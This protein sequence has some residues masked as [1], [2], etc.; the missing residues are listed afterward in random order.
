MI[1]EN[2]TRMSPFSAIEP[3]LYSLDVCSPGFDIDTVDIV[4]DRNNLRKLLRFCGSPGERWVCLSD[5]NTRILH[6]TGMGN[7]QGWKLRNLVLPHGPLGPHTS[8]L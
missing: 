1:D 2:G 6:C 7:K 5:Q 4:T 8:R 3:L